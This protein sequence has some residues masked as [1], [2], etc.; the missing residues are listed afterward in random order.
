MECGDAL[1]RRS[2]YSGTE[3]NC[4]EVAWRKSSL[5]NETDCVEVAHRSGVVGIRDSKCPEAG[6]LTVPHTAFH[7]LRQGLGRSK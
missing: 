7:Q 2:S 1:R 5:S 4:V 3:T 6:H